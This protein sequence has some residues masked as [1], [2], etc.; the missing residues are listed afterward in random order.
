MEY[1]QLPRPKEFLIVPDMHFLT[2]SNHQK[3]EKPQK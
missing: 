2:R 3:K 1:I